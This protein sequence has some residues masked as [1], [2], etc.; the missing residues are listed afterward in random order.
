MA[1]PAAEEAEESEAEAEAEAVEEEALTRAA[2]LRSRCCC[3]PPG[4]GLALLPGLTAGS[5]A[6]AVQINRG[7]RG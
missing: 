6:F 3:S 4:T 7:A 1:A 2:G 5:T